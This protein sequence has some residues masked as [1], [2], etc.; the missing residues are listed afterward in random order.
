MSRPCRLDS[1]DY[2][3]LRQYFLT[4]CARQRGRF[5]TDPATVALVLAHFLR[6]ATD[7]SFEVLAYCFMPDHLHL[8]VVAR[9]EAA[10]LQRFVRLAKQRSGFSFVHRA[11][12]R[13]W[14]ESYYERVIRSEASLP[15][16]VEYVLGNPVRAGL[17]T[18]PAEYPH[19][20]SQSYSREDLLEFVGS[21][22]RV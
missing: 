4:I 13:L 20:G 6:V 12:R 9:S 2:V 11:G 8:I 1:P 5:F 22:R 18:S 7:E 15:G 3:G 17:A 21:V 10:D 19:W 16:I 14:Q